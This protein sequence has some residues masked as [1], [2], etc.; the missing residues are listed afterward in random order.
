MKTT[1]ALMM[2]MMAVIIGGAVTLI[3]IGGAHTPD[4]EVI[5]LR[6]EVSSLRTDIQELRKLQE[7]DEPEELPGQIFKAKDDL[8]VRVNK[9]ENRIDEIVDILGNINKELG[10]IK[11]DIPAHPDPHPLDSVGGFLAELGDDPE[12]AVRGFLQTDSGRG[13][14]TMAHRMMVGDMARRLELDEHQ[15]RAFAG[16]MDRGFEEFMD[17]VSGMDERTPRDEVRR[18]MFRIM[19]QSANEVEDILDHEQL[20]KYREMQEQGIRLPGSE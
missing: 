15:R 11:E 6:S 19:Q 20:E 1:T 2:I 12:E 7:K 16:I 18:A 4:N 8:D 3:A 17:A 10:E 5:S 9:L 13:F 14:A